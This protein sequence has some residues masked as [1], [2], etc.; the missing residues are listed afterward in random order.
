[1]GEVRVHRSAVDGA[2]YVK[3][4]K[5]EQMNFTTFNATNIAIDKANQE[6]DSDLMTTSEDKLKV[7]GYI[8]MQYNLK[9]GLCKFGA[10]GEVAAI[11]KMTQLHIMD[12]W[13]AMDPSKLTQEDRIKALSLV[14][15]LKEKQTGK[16]KGRACINGAPQRA[17]ISKEEA[18]LP[19][20]STES[21]FITEA[22][23][24]KK[25]DALDVTTSQACS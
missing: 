9:P 7:W 14:L 2:K 22:I 20:V 4:T 15:F 3:M 25:R 21:T 11:T 1:M 18:A 16:I 23:A 24:A 8:M 10:R 19:T 5:A 13:T 12:T 17:Y 6:I